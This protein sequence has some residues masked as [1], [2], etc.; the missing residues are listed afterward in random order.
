VGFR[1]TFG[2]LELHVLPKL[3]KVPVSD[4]DQNDIWDVFGPIWHTKAETA[5]K[6]TNRLGICLTHAVALGLEVDLQA[7]EKARSL[8][9][10]QRHKAQNVPAFDAFLSEG[11]VTYLALRLLIRTGVRSGPV[12]FL[13]KDQIGGDVWTI[14]GEGMKSRKDKRRISE[15]PCRKK[16]KTF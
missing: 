12:R 1:C 8:L 2:P 13:K 16:R 9:G 14:P 3:G 4:T 10:K 7:T 5:R 15:C 6:A 11:S